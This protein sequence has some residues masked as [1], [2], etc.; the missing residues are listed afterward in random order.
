MDDL[1]TVDSGP[2]MDTQA[3]DTDSAPAEAQQTQAAPKVASTPSLKELLK[4]EKEDA[5]VS[6]NDAELDVLDEHY[7]KQDAGK[8]P[9]AK[10][11]PEAPE[12]DEEDTEVAPKSKEKAEVEEEPEESEPDE[13][14]D[15]AKAIL[16]EVG[17]KSL[18]EVTAKIKELRK[19]LSGKDAQA[20]AKITKERDDLA[21]SG[22]SLWTALAKG[23]AKAME[24]AEKQFGVKFAGS[25]PQQVQQSKTSEGDEYVSPDQFI[26]PESAKLVNAAFKRMEDRIK[27]TE[28]KFGTIEQERDRHAQ[29]N[30]HKE[31]TRS[32]A[33][34]MVT[35]AERIPELKSIPGL[36][37]AVQNVLDGKPDPRLDVFNE[38]FDIAKEENCSLR[39]AFDIKR[40]RNTDRIE[41]EAIQKGLK[42]AY[43]QKPN[44]SLSGQTGGKGEA[45]YQPVTPSLL[46]KWESDHN[47]HPES[48]YS[49]DGDILQNKVPKSAWKIFGFK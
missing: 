29:E 34:E 16:K 42:Q 10:T 37:E 2:V 30:T 20:V 21:N 24:F 14:D 39:A 32:V 31:A 5:N 35:I 9:K 4:R 38:L 26:D 23:D 13:G 3:P 11:E 40:G 6:F 19:G 27:A 8:K 33:S 47:S 28:G 25:Q 49:K 17:A 15:D 12:I 41:A 48:W 43:S 46:E 7:A 45:S 1:A 18:K 36:R 44:P 22:R